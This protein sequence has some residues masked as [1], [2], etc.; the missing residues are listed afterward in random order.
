MDA[1][2]GDRLNAR[3]GNVIKEENLGFVVDAR[4]FLAN[5][6]IVCTLTCPSSWM[7]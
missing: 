2:K 1:G 7:L 5:T 4:I 3:S 6:S